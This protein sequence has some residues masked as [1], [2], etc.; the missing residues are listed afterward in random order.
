MQ[1]T[2]DFLAGRPVDRL[3]FHPIVMRWAA[4]HA[5]V[6]YRDFCLEPAAKCRAMIQAADDFEMDW[7]TV[8]SDPYAEA[9]AFGLQVD[10]PDDDLPVERGGRLPDL[11]AVRALQPYCVDAG[12][13]RL[14]NRV[15]EVREFRRQAGDRLFIV[16]WVEGPVAEYV[17]IRGASD[18]AMDLLD[19]P[20]AVDGAMDIVTDCA[21]EFI[22]AQ[23]EAGAHCLGIGDAFCSQIGPKLYR[24]F[25]WARE[26]RMVEHI[27]GLGAIAKLHICGNTTQI[28]PDMIATGADIVD[29]DHLVASMSPFASLLAPNQV[30]SGSADPV[31]VI[32]DGT[33]DQIVAAVRECRQQT[34]DRCIVSAGCEITPDTTEATMRVFQSTTN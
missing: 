25:A 23:V 21:L 3:P 8:M 33:P 22:T 4:R 11:D 14:F 26:K 9:S 24:R 12:H 19:D 2:L 16:G 27:H 30:L 10:Y 5:G 20:S 7:V 13:G 17:D 28:L 34:N 1:R 18:A 29:V 32:Q 15:A 6:K 31:S